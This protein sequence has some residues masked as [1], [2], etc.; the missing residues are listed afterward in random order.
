MKPIIVALREQGLLLIFLDDILLIGEKF[1]TVNKNIRITIYLLTSLGL[2]VSLSKSILKPVQ[3]ISNS[4]TMEISR[5][6]SE[7]D[8]ITKQCNKLLK[9]QTTSIREISTLLCLLE[10]ARPAIHIAPLHY[11]EIQFLPNRGIQNAP[12]LQPALHPKSQSSPG[13]SLVEVK[14][15]Q[16][17]WKP[18][19]R[20]RP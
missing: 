1:S 8:K 11:R 10:A 19:F 17:Q 18:N 2:L 14:Y 6:I 15:P 4:K 5:P 16:G 12:K 3:L 20:L 9:M 7:P 13:N